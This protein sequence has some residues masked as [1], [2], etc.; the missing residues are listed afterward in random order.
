M[1]FF[2]LTLLPT[3]FPPSKL[4]GLM[5][6]ASNP[7]VLYASLNVFIVPLSLL[8][9]MFFGFFPYQPSPLS[10]TPN[11]QIFS[12]FPSTL[13]PLL[14]LVGKTSIVFFPNNIL[15]LFPQDFHDYFHTKILSFRTNRSSSHTSTASSPASVSLSH[16]SSI[17][18]TDLIAIINPAKEP[19]FS[20]C[21]VCTPTEVLK[22]F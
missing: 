10:S 2:S 1:C 3:A 13:F 20:W 15:I 12:S 22:R 11:T 17:T 19:T 4:L 18:F 16:F 9:L 21:R 7:N 14:H 5:V 6:N 8:P